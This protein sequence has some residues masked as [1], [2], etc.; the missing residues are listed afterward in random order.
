MDTILKILTFNTSAINGVIEN[1][2]TISPGDPLGK[3]QIEVYID[4][5]LIGTF[6]FE[7]VPF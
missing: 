3:H 6:V 2:W 5:R 1:F 4:E 7:I